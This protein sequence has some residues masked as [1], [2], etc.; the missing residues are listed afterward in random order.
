M[1]STWLSPEEYAATPPEATL[2]GSVASGGE[3]DRPV[4]LHAVHSAEHPWQWPGGTA[5]PG[6]PP[7]D[8]AV[9]E[10]AEETGLVVP[11]PPRLPTAVF[12]LPGAAWPFATS[13]LVFDCGR[14]T[15]RQ[16]TGITLAPDE[17]DEVRV[18]P[19][20]DWRGLMPER[21]FARLAAVMEARRTGM[22]AHFDT[23]DW[24]A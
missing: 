23:W 21:D 10:T 12:G 15:D 3:S 22:A 11:G 6:E 4:H 1:S 2:F 8:T 20:A 9:R 7:W 14:L 16:L 24:D 13:G 18:L 5:E 17:H 19:L